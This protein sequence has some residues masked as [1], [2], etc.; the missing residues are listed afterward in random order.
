[1]GFRYD[2]TAAELLSRLGWGEPA[3]EKLLAQAEAESGLKVPAVLREFLCLAAGCPLLETSDLW[4]K[5]PERLFTLYGEI[6]DTISH[7]RKY[8]E[9][10]PEEGESSDWVQFWKLPQERWGELTENYLLIGS[11]YGAGVVQFGIRTADLEE[12]DPPVYW[13]HECDPITDWKL[14]DKSVSDFL[15]RTL[16]DVLCC[17]EYG[18]AERVLKKAGWTARKLRRSDLPGLGCGGSAMLRWASTYGADAVCGY[19]YDEEARRLAVIREDRENEDFFCGME[20]RFV[21]YRQY[22]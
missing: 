14:W 17:G 22:T 2:L 16:C 19:G 12:A 13:N 21:Q 15:M 3:G 7:S 8:W 4:T 10:N 6:Q 1:M 20:Y 5:R 11:D 18:T 9:E